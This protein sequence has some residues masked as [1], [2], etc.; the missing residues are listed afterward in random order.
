MNTNQ[1]MMSWQSISAAEAQVGVAPAL[2]PAL[3]VEFTPNGTQI[4]SNSCR[5]WVRESAWTQRFRAIQV[6]RGFLE[7]CDIGTV[8]TEGCDSNCKILPGYSCN[9]ATGLYSSQPRLDECRLVV[10]GNGLLETGEMCDDRNNRS[11]DGCSS[12]CHA[13]LDMILAF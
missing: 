7:E 13:V 3:G 4:C 10:C 5:N 6:S 12:T 2:F 8:L 11:G 9:K 1:V